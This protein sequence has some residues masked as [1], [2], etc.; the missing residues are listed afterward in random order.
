M[1]LSSSVFNIPIGDVLGF[2]RPAYRLVYG[3]KSGKAFICAGSEV[4][5]KRYEQS[6][7]SM[8]DDTDG[9]ASA[10]LK[11]DDVLNLY[12]ILNYKCNFRCSYC[13]SA[14]GR[15]DREISEKALFAMIRYFLFRRE[16]RDLRI[17]FIGGGE[18]FVSR[19]LL[20][21]AIRL[22][23]TLEPESGTSVEVSVVTNGSLLTSD[24]LNF[25]SACHVKLKISFDVLEDLQNRQRGQYETVSANVRI[26]STMLETSLR[27]VVTREGVDRIDQ[28]VEECIREYPRVRVLRCDPVASPGYFSSAEEA[29]IFYDRYNKSFLRA[30]DRADG[31]LTLSNVCTRILHSA[32]RRLCPPL[33]TLTPDDKITACVCFS[34]PQERGF[35]E[36]VFGR[37]VD[38]R[39]ELEEAEFHRV[40]EV[41]GSGDADCGSCF[42]KYNCA[43]GCFAHRRCHDGAVWKIACE[44]RRD[45]ARRLIVRDVGRAYLRNTGHRLEDVL[46]KGPTA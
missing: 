6:V 11:L 29:R 7:R 20:F 40:M 28:M 21:D 42:L 17:I 45:L 37:I 32:R 22:I 3:G 24:A 38:G 8:D 12:V 23:R 39:V 2:S 43:G 9:E 26:A 18:P 14:S 13:Y 19:G 35:S 27:S 4:G 36:T 15:S 34:S 5:S 46:G 31:H 1:S 30:L 16:G 10:S 44:A 25:L 33:F 41:T